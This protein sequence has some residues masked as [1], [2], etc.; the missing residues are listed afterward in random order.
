MA[1]SV[2]LHSES[3]IAKVDLMSGETVGA[4]LRDL[5]GIQIRGYGFTPHKSTSSCTQS[6]VSLWYFQSDILRWRESS[7]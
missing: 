2:F 7:A 5:L 4:S 1:I 3:H 6:L